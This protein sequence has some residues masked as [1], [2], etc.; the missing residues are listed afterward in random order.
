MRSSSPAPPSSI[1]T[2]CS[3][4][5]TGRRAVAANWSARRSTFLPTSTPC[6]VRHAFTPAAGA[7]AWQISSNAQLAAAPVRAAVQMVHEAGLDALRARSLRLTDYLME[8]IDE[9]GGPPFDFRVGNP[10]EPER[11]GGHVAVE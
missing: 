5:S 10:R 9:L 3:A 11:R 8:W 4:R 7:G 6:K 2:R 1:C